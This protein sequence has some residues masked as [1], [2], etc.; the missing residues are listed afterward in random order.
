MHNS[1]VANRLI[2]VIYSQCVHSHDIQAELVELV[3]AAKAEK[4]RIEVS[5]AHGVVASIALVLVCSC[6]CFT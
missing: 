2:A 5:H 1:I 4:A 6:S 3:A